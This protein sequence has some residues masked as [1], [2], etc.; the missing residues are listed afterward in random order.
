MAA[1]FCAAAARN[2]NTTKTSIDR[3]PPILE[4]VIQRIQGF[5]SVHVHND[6]SLYI[7]QTSAL[8]DPVDVDNVTD[9]QVIRGTTESS[10]MSD[11]GSDVSGL[12][13][14]NV[15]KIN[16]TEDIEKLEE[17]VLQH[18][19]IEDG[20]KQPQFEVVVAVT[21]KDG[22]PVKPWFWNNIYS[23]LVFI[24][25]NKINIYLKSFSIYI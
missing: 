7:Y 20:T 9:A 6:H 25:R 12:A 15:V 23:Y 22:L 19:T 1:I 13:T 21:T 3:F 5:Y 8:Y 17:Y 14:E 24:G 10:L 18:H 2:L 11:G 16:R 4:Y